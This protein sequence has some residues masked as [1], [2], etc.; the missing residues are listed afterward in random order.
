MLDL[1]AD[2]ACMLENERAHA[3]LCISVFRDIGR[4]TSCF[5]DHHRPRH[6]SAGQWAPTIYKA[7]RRPSL[8]SKFAAVA[9][10]SSRKSALHCENG[11]CS[12]GLQHWDGKCDFSA[13]RTS[14]ED[15][16]SCSTTLYQDWAS[17]DFFPP[18]SRKKITQ[19]T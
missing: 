17:S 9:E 10:K 5:G 2:M 14:Q 1:R 8:V 4:A 11:G 3:C 16:R 19:N 7:S 6:T 12:G 18:F 15:L 13:T